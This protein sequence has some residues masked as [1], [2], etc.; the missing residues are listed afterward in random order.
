MTKPSFPKI[1]L[2]ASL[3]RRLQLCLYLLQN[4]PIMYRV[5]VTHGYVYAP[6][7]VQA[8]CLHLEWNYL[9]LVDVEGK[10]VGSSDY[11]SLI[12]VVR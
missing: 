11:V 1:V 6:E 2:K 12:D 10:A 7:P 9:H 4:K 5:G 3:R 8:D